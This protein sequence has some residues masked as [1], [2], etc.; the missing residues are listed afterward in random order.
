MS[1]LN[2]VN[3]AFLDEMHRALPRRA[4]RDD[5]QPYLSE[6]RGI[7]TGHAGAVLA[8]GDAGEVAAIL[9]AA[10]KAR[11]AVI[12]FSGGTGLVGGQVA[13]DLAA[14]I[15]LSTERM[16][17]IHAVYPDEN[18]FIVGAG[19]ILQDVRAK[20][21]KAGRYFPLMLG[22]QGSAR[23]GGLLATNAGGMNVLRYGNAR[24]L[25]LGIEAV[26]ADGTVIHG[27]KRLRK[28]NT[29]YDLRNLLIGSEGTLG[30][31]TAA[32]LRLFRKPADTVT[33][34][35][36]V[37]NPKAALEL[38]ALAQELAGDTLSVFELMSGT[39]FEFMART[40]PERRL[41][42]QPIPDWSVLFEVGLAAGLDARA[43]AE[44]L[45]EQAM[46]AGL[47]LDG[48]IA[49]GAAQRDA[50]LETRELIPEANRRIGAISSHD[51]SVP[52]S[53][54]PQFIEE[55]RARVLAHG[56]YRINCFGHLGDGNLHYNLYP[57]QG[58][59]RAAWIGRSHEIARI[60][61]DLVAEF[62]GSFSAEHGIGRLKT[63]D[64]ERYG[65]PGRLAAMKAIKDALDPNGILNPGAVLA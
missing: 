19:A 45:F 24:D 6:P 42:L 16:N 28:D 35:L 51:I 31:I 25:C 54:I 9:R 30:I 61:H 8:P 41:P 18:V 56:P 26:L 59:D 7:W 21:E 38:L 32:S 39:G 49:Q 3:P 63:G 33:G 44:R 2:P 1:R 27:L 55:A 20:A 14:P 29:G 40:M 36:A 52:L 57:P 64:L 11:I 62:D 53:A 60:L 22:S 5:A 46:G 17:A 34:Y 37:P 12:P 13:P 48:V 15:V 4:F 58:E 23:I 10:N 43:V 65:D 50:F 47:V